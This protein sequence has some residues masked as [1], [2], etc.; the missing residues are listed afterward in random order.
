MPSSDV[1]HRDL[2]RED[3]TRSGAFS[4]RTHYSKP[5]VQSEGYEL[6]QYSTQYNEESTNL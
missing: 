1:N 2:D 5:V 4:P 3:L 6:E